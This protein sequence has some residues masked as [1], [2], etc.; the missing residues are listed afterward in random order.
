MRRTLPV[1]TGVALVVV[2]AF[3]WLASVFPSLRSYNGLSVVLSNSAEIAILAAG[4]TLVIATG[5]I[6]IS[7]GSVAGFCAVLLGV[8]TVQLGWPVGASVLAC[9]TAGGLLG[10]ING[11]LIARFQ[12]PPIVATLA[13][14]AAARAGAYVLSRGDSIS[15]LP[16]SLVSFGYGTYLGVPGPIY[17]AVAALF[18][19]GILLKRTSFGRAVLAIGGGRETAYLSG[20]STAAI[21]ALVYVISGALAALAAIVMVARGATAIPDAGRFTEMTAITAV[22]MGGTPITGGKATMTGTALGVLGIGLITNGVRAYGKGD[23]WVLLVL[24]I[25]LLLS[26]EVDRWRTRERSIAL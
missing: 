6:D 8:L 17:P 9:L 3:L 7:V 11:T 21:E 23:I 26:V 12:L 16:S 5:G 10:G 22:V 18:L 14:F 13:M 25:A 15:G 20:L 4:M 24:G 19:C 2:V 1:E